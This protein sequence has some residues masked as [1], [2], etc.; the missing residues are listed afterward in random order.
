MQIKGLS[1]DKIYNCTADQITKMEL[2]E[3]NAHRY[4][5]VT[6]HIAY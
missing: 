4:F 2:A 3:L 5:T 6:R 1:Q